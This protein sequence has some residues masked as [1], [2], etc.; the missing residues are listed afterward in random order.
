MAIKARDAGA[1]LF[2]VLGQVDA[3]FSAAKAATK[4]CG[5]PVK[6]P[7]DEPGWAPVRLLPQG[8]HGWMTRLFNHEAF[9]PM[10]AELFKD[11][12]GPEPSGWGAFFG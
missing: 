7:R 9:K 6:S 5:W 12:S 11:F 10:E 4:A 8:Q 1:D 3:I 2:S